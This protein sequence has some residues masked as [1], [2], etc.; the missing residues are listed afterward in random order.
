MSLDNHRYHHSHHHRS[1]QPKEQGPLI[2]VTMS[3]V[4]VERMNMQDGQGG[5]YTV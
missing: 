5:A 4:A 2:I 1:A 3:Q